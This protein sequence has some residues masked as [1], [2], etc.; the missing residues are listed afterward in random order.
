MGVYLRDL[1]NLAAMN[2]L[3]EQRV[4]TPL[5]VRTTI[6]ADLPGFEIEVDAVLYTGE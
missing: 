5:P 1:G 4:P 3:Y 6:Q 2:A